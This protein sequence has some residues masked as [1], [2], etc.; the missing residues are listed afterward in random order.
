MARFDTGHGNL[1][2]IKGEWPTVN[3][4]SL[5]FNIVAF[6]MSTFW[7][8]IVY[9]MVHRVSSACKDMFVT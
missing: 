3:N 2:D 8:L 6:P 4:G 1:E 7:P 9:I 5:G